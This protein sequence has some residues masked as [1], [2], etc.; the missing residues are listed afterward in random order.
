MVFFDLWTVST[1][2]LMAFVDWLLRMIECF[3]E[4]TIVDNEYGGSVDN[5]STLC[6]SGTDDHDALINVAA[7]STDNSGR[8]LM[9]IW[10]LSPHIKM[11]YR[12]YYTL[13]FFVVET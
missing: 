1:N 4:M 12:K 9:E 13:S 7:D 8:T 2:D 11:H 3:N 5:L 6:V 10:L